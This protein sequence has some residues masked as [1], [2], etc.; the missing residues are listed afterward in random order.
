M[1]Y[2]EDEN[3]AITVY[4]HYDY[5][6]SKDGTAIPSATEMAYS[7]TEAGSYTV[8]ITPDKFDEKTSAVCAVQ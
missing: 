3:G 5:Q 6:W 7:P 4:H 1:T 8:T 2:W